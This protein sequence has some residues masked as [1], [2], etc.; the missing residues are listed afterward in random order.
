LGY[1]KLPASVSEA[2]IAKK[3]L[4]DALMWAFDK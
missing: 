1:R 3:L 2:S 4:A